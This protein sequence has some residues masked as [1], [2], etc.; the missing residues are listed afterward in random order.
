M[1]ILVYTRNSR[2]GEL[3]DDLRE[4]FAAEDRLRFRNADAHTVGEIE[5]CDLVLVDDDFPFVAQDYRGAEVAP[6]V[7]LFEASEVGAPEPPEPVGPSEDLHPD[8][9]ASHTA[10]D[11]AVEGGLGPADFEGVEPRGVTG[12]TTAQIREMVD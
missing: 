6:T 4:R 9:F 12:Y 5:A 1:D 7:E 3:E 2:I 11:A 8:D 10:F